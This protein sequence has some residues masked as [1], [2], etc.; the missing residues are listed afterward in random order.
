MS[1]EI[2]SVINHES[3]R[4]L[5]EKFIRV[6]SNFLGVVSSITFLNNKAKN[7]KFM[8]KKPSMFVIN[9]YLIE[10]DVYNLV[11]LLIHK[12]T[13]TCVL[14][15]FSWIMLIESDWGAWL[16]LQYI[17]NWSNTFLVSRILH[18]FKYLWT[19]E[20]LIRFKLNYWLTAKSVEL[21]KLKVNR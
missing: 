9:W 16:V 12:F 4:Y 3:I 1:A 18:F 15:K 14:M 2:W 21:N 5:H 8:M 7:R 13:E 6:C 11:K 20:V 19:L 17:I 10:A